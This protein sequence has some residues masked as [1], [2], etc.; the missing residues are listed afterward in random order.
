MGHLVR[1]IWKTEQLL[2][3]CAEESKNI[4]N[5][6]FFP[7]CKLQWKLISRHSMIA[8]LHKRKKFLWEHFS[9]GMNELLQSKCEKNIL[10]YMNGGKRNVTLSRI[11]FQD[12]YNLIGWSNFNELWIPEAVYISLKYS[13][14]TMKTLWI[15]IWRKEMGKVI[16]NC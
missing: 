2:L 16:S 9:A 5:I 6:F 12:W 1:R 11:R 10:I 8:N 3:I 13:I 7:A 14:Q 4:F 15:P